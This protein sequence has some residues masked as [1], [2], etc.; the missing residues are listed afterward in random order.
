M[1]NLF[2]TDLSDLIGLSK[3]ALHIHLGLLAFFAAMLVFRR[4]PASIVPWL[5]VLALELVNEAFDLAH[6]LEVLGSV[7][8]IAN[9]MLWPTVILLVARFA[10]RFLAWRNSGRSV[11]P[12][13]QAVDR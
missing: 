7:K 9:T 11:P 12:A 3:D 4:S 1:F 5:F 8:D 2:K 13:A 6:E 10:P